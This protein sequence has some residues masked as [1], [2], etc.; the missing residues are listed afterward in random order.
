MGWKDTEK[1][2]GAERHHQSVRGFILQVKRSL[3]VIIIKLGR[4]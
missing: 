4:G 3:A 2:E 1:G